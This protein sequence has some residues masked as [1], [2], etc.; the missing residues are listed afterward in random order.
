VR[1]RAAPN[2]DAGV[3]ADPVV[4]QERRAAGN[5]GL[6]PRYLHSCG[7]CDRHERRHD[8]H[9]PGGWSSGS[10]CILNIQSL[11]VRRTKGRSMRI[12]VCPIPRSNWDRCEVVPSVSARHTARL[13]M[14]LRA[15]SLIVAALTVLLATCATAGER[16][17][18]ID[19]D[20]LRCGSERVRIEGVH[21]PELSEPGGQE[22]RQRLQKRIQSGELVIQRGGRDKYG[23]TLGRVY[24]NGS[25]ITQIDVSPKAARG[26]K[27]I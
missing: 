2:D 24:V 9:S 25:R 17:A 13:G 21:A 27:R 18:A 19:G 23:R 15:Y 26:T 5:L 11:A 10:L 6:L 1:T 8:L 3:S 20:T 7:G 22:A 4:G 16:C 14:L 12:G